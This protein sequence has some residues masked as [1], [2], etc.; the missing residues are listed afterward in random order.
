M[1][2]VITRAEQ[3]AINR[4]REPL[5]LQGQRLAEHR[6]S[7]SSDEERFGRLRVVPAADRQAEAA[8]AAQADR[9]RMPGGGLEPTRD[10]KGIA[11]RLPPRT[12]VIYVIMNEPQRVRPLPRAGL[13]EHFAVRVD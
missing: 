6:L 11:G 8:H 1:S 10:V 2:R 5:Q 9:F 13:G 3:T 12:A 4:T 7:G